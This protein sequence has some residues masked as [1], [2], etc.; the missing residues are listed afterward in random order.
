VIATSRDTE[1]LAGLPVTALRF[2]TANDGDIRNLKAVVDSEMRVLISTPV[3]DA[4][5]AEGVNSAARIVFLSTTGVYGAQREV[6][7][8]SRPAPRTERESARLRSEEVLPPEA[9]ILRPAAIYG[10]ERGIHSAM[11]VGKYLLAGDG[12]NYVS[13]I[14][15]DDLAAHAAAALF[16]DA[17]GAWPV[18]DEEP[19]TSR[20][21]AEFCAELLGIP[22]P[23]S[24]ALEELSETRQADRRVD[25]SAVRRLLGLTLLYPSYR[26][27][28]PACVAAEAATRAF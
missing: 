9:M 19:C 11:R 25:G 27:G 7:E 12:S 16:A 26:S 15:V 6:N 17:S 22:M 10:P 24:A 2:D 28:I 23:P 5:L 18:A 8:G 3:V 14:H 20:E 13:R 4:R 1:S 21:I